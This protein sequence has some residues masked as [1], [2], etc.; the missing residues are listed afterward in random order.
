MNM[1]HGTH[2]LSLISL[3]GENPYCLSQYWIS[4]PMGF[5]LT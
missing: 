1:E 2:S 4:F 5:E 3:Q